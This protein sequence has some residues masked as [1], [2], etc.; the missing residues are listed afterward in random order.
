MR[1]L[2][3]VFHQGN[4]LR[5]S[6]L[7]DPRHVD[8]DVTG[9]VNDGLGEV[10]ALGDETAAVVG[11]LEPG[12]RIVALGAH[13]LHE[14]ESVRLADGVVAQQAEIGGRGRP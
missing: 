1:T 5:T 8:V 3:R 9:L 4:A 10:A 13:L 11:P 6:Y 7:A 14:G 12:D 2:L